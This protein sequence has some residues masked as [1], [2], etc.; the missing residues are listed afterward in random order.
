MTAKKRNCHNNGKQGR[1]FSFELVNFLITLFSFFLF[2]YAIINSPRIYSSLHL[3]KVPLSTTSTTSTLKSLFEAKKKTNYLSIFS[4]KKKKQNG[5]RRKEYV[6]S[7]S[8]AIK[9]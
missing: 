9:R 8:D 4:S 3:N 5:E 6:P 2:N 1:I 7:L